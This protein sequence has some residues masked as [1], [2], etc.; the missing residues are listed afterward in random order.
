VQ[1]DLVPGVDD[2]PAESGRSGQFTAENEERRA[3]IVF[4]QQLEEERRRA[5]V[6]AVVEG[7]GDVPGVTDTGQARQQCGTQGWDEGRRRGDV[8]EPRRGRGGDQRPLHP[9]TR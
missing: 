6:R 8:G 7:E 9:A 1:G 4:G 5:G 2:F 3:H